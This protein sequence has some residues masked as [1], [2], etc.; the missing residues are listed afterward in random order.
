M[1]LTAGGLRAAAAA[2]IGGAGF[3]LDA[4]LAALAAWGA[5]ASARAAWPHWEV[6]RSAWGNP[7][8]LLDAVMG[9]AEPLRAAGAYALSFASLALLG[10][11]AAVLAVAALE[12]ARAALRRV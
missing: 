7:R 11:L 10:L 3:L 9:A 5:S 1:A 8:G 6:A 2:G 12:G 4:G